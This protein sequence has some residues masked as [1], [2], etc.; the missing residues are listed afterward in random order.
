MATVRRKRCRA[1][2]LRDPVGDAHADS[3]GRNPVASGKVA[4]DTCF[5]CH[6]V[7]LEAGEME[8][9]LHGEGDETTGAV[10]RAILNFVKRK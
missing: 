6:G 3:A 10:M 4:V 9:L 7:F 1:G 2:Q 8:R 5:N